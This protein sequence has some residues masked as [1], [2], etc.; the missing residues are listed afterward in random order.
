MLMV[1]E[2]PTSNTTGISMDWGMAFVAC[3]IRVAL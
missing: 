3:K 1:D 2:G